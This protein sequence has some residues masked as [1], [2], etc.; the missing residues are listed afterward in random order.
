MGPASGR[1]AEGAVRPERRRRPP[2]VGARRAAAHGWAVFHA[3]GDPRDSML[4]AATNHAVYGATVQRS[5]DGG[6][7]WERTERLGLPEETG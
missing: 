7:T 6:E 3:I 1:N 2:R 5:A 4:F